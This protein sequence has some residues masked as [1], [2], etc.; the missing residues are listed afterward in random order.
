MVSPAR[1]CVIALER[2]S[3]GPFILM[4]KV[5]MERKDPRTA[6]LHLR[7]AEGMDSPNFIT[8]NLLGQAY[9]SLGQEQE[10]K[11]EF[12]AA[13]NQSPAALFRFST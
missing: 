12:D 7:H 6:L 5:L 8:D 13:V 9:G 3:T 11:Q 4:G 2:S 1:N 10:A